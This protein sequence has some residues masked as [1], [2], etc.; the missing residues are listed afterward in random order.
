MLRSSVGTVAMVYQSS[1]QRLLPQRSLCEPKQR[2][3]ALGAN[4]LI[5]VAGLIR[6]QLVSET[7]LSLHGRQVVDH[8]VRGERLAAAK[9]RR[10]LGGSPGILVEAH[11]ELRRTL[12]NVKEFSEGQP[13]QREYH[14]D[15]MD[16]GEEV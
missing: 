7:E 8:H 5:V 11:A 6:R 14:R 12:E 4:L 3:T 2:P 16:D 10:L 15:R 1:R 13:Q 9:A